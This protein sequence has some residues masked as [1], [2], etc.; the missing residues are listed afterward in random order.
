M[1]SLLTTA[2]LWLEALIVVGLT[3][4]AAMLGPSLVRRFV[5]LENLS[6]NNEIAGFK[7][8]TI[9]VLYAVLLAFSIILVWQKYSDTDASVAKE[10]GAAATIYHLS[11][12][13]GEPQGAAVRAAMTNYL[14]SAI[15]DEWPAMDHGVA[16]QQTGQRLGAIYTALLASQSFEQNN[17]A[18]M[19]EIFYQLDVLTQ[20]RRVRLLAADGTVPVVVWII[21]FGGAVVTVVFTFFFGTQSL[22]AQTLMT[23]L[24]SLLI[25][26]ELL[27]VIALDRPFSGGIKEPPQALVEILADFGA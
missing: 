3:T 27:I 8:A 4:A 19:S 22:R 17:T 2:P 9:G 5:T 6:T 21:L 13:M 16:S 12:G 10:A 14:K 24:L 15:S 26:S 25:F 7:F 23:G 18:L 1:I 20:A 11:R